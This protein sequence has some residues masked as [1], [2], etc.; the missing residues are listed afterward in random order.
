MT[1]CSHCT[2]TFENVTHTSRILTEVLQR[3]KHA[4]ERRGNASGKRVDGLPCRAIREQR[5][6][7]VVAAV[8]ALERHGA[9]EPW[10]DAAGILDILPEDELPPKG[11]ISSRRELA[12]VGACELTL[13]NGMKV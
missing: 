9:I 4:T 11:T 5:I 8:E 13:G 12:H 10:D 7:E 6:Q 1:A 2:S 3:R